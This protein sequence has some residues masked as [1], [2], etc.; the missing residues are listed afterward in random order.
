M[1]LRKDLDLQAHSQRR[2]TN[3]SSIG[4]GLSSAIRAEA[5]RWKATSW[6]LLLSSHHYSGQ[7]TLP[8]SEKNHSCSNCVGN[9]SPIRASLAV[10]RS[11]ERPSGREHPLTAGHSTFAPTSLTIISRTD[12]NLLSVRL[13]SNPNRC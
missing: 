7:T 9:P 1:L 3:P 11:T 5:S 10:R 12:V 2:C 8:G 13:R 4:R 6:L